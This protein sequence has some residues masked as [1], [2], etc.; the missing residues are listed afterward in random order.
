MKLELINSDASKESGQYIYDK[1]SAMLEEA[2]AQQEKHN[3]LYNEKKEQCEKKTTTKADYVLVNGA[4]MTP[5]ACL[6]E[7]EE[8]TRKKEEINKKIE[9]MNKTLEDLNKVL[10]DESG[11]SLSTLKDKFIT[12]S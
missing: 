3:S 10:N 6:A 9:E 1:V 5:E 8:Y 12:S 7:K 2:K 11:D 4:E